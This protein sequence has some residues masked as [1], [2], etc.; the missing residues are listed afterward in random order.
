VTGQVVDYK[1]KLEIIVTD[2]SQLKRILYFKI[3]VHAKAAGN[4]GDLST[5][6]LH[7]PYR[8]IH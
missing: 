5:L 1:S 7:L 3:N 2:P 6:R 4:P 8:V